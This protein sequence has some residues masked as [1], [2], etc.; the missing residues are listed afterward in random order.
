MRWLIDVIVAVVIF[1]VGVGLWA[2]MR[3]D[4]NIEQ[5]RDQTKSAV[6][7]L[8]REVRIRSATGA[9]II[10]GRGWPLTINHKWFDESI[11]RN[12]LITG[13]RPWIDVAPIEHANLIHPIVRIVADRTTAEFWYNP[14]NGV[15]RARVP[16]NL[17]DA[18][19]TSLYNSVN[20]AQLSSIFSDFFTEG[21]ARRLIKNG[22]GPEA[23]LADAAE[24]HDPNHFDPDDLDPT[25]SQKD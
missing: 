9:T 19:A 3:A 8:S 11:P 18:E 24:D 22:P 4:N 12:E 23:V 17:P 10:N 20:G 2:T 6:H 25:A 5:R 16:A 21:E 14:G 7:T 13:S 15:V 1:A